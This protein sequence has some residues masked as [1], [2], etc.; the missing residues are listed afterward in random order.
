MP[1]C[2]GK[3][4]IVMARDD[5]S[6]WV[7][8]RALGKA[9]AQN[10]ARFLWEDVICRHGCFGKLIVDGGPENVIELANRYGIKRVVVVRMYKSGY[11][12][13]AALTFYRTSMTHAN[14]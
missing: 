14:G 1:A 12:I 5:F 11:F 2:R 4:Y 9:T 6:G 3:H 13:S 10:V 8:G 7:E